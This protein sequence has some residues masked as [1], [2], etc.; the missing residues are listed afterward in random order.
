VKG[1]ILCVAL[2]L[3]A[4]PAYALDAD[5]KLWRMMNEREKTMFLVGYLQ[6]AAATHYPKESEPVSW[7]KG[8]KIGEV[9]GLVDAYCF[10]RENDSDE[11][12]MAILIITKRWK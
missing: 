3:L 2:V 10:R 9:T 11:L 7:P 5:C 4:V 1:I 6:G 12:G 8:A